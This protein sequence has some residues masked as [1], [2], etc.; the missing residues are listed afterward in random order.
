MIIAT[1]L[2][3]QTPTT[4]D[5]VREVVKHYQS[6]KTFSMS[7]EHSDSSGLFPGKYTQDFTFD[8]GKFSLTVT[9]PKDSKVPN[10]SCDGKE[11]TTDRNG[12]KSTEPL[13]TDPNLMPGWEV[14]GGLIVSWLMKTPSAGFLF[15]PPQGFKLV[16]SPGKKTKWQEIDVN[17]VVVQMSGGQETISVMLYLS[18]DNKWLVGMEHKSNGN[19]GWVKYTKQVGK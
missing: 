9:S 14:S 16:M 4:T 13:N 11:V 5:T 15:N 18:K 10:Y 12:S 17:E 1:L 3:C 8:N 6:L 19:G 7:I 2:L